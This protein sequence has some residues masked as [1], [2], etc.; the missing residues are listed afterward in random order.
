MECMYVCET[1]TIFR[2]I[3][4]YNNILILVLLHKLPDNV[5]QNNDNSGDSQNSQTGCN[6]DK[7][8]SRLI[9]AVFG[10]GATASS[11][12]FY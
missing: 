1:T 12:H 2:F 6:Q 7:P 10:P 5:N 8:V 9:L 3:Y 11:A 4:V